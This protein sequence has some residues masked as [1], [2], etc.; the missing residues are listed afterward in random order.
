MSNKKSNISDRKLLTLN[1]S[2]TLSWPF[3]LCW[4]FFY[5]VI[6]SFMRKAGRKLRP[7]LSSDPWFLVFLAVARKIT[8]QNF[9]QMPFYTLFCF[10]FSVN[11]QFIYLF[12][13][14]KQSMPMTRRSLGLANLYQTRAFDF[15][16]NSYIWVK[17]FLNTRMKTSAVS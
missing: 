4:L 3:V 5:S 17:T 8:L 14:N 9:F 6:G 2:C 11:C 16:T 10:G 15:Y 1:Q 13:S 12:I 7:S